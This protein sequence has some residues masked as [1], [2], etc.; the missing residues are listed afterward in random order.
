M[1][2][3]NT[4]RIREYLE[5]ERDITFKAYGMFGEPVKIKYFGEGFND[6]EVLGILE[7]FKMNLLKSID[8]RKDKKGE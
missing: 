3:P 8:Y 1:A 6:L 2:H 7:L 4:N 5:K